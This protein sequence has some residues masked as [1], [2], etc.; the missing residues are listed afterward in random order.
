MTE[1]VLA[2][3]TNSPH[4]QPDGRS[5]LSRLVDLVRT[6]RSVS[7]ETLP[8]SGWLNLPSGVST[9]GVLWEDPASAIPP[10]TEATVLG[11]P[12]F[13]R[14]VELLASALANAPLAAQRYDPVLD[15]WL[16][17]RPGPPVLS[18][19][20]NYG[21][22]WGWHY[23]ATRDLILFG[24]HFSRLADPD[25]DGMPTRLIPI[26]ATKVELAA[27]PEGWLAWRIDGTP[28]PW[29]DVFHVSA[30]NRSGFILGRG[31][32]A[33]YRDALSGALA[34][35]SHARRYMASG[36]L[37]SA[38]L[39]SKNPDLTQEQ[40][41]AMKA[42]YRETIGTGSR[43]PLVLPASTEFTPVVSDADKQQLV[44]A[45]KWDAAEA[46]MILGI[47]TVKLGLPGPTMTYTNTQMSEIEYRTNTLSRWTGPL[48][49]A[50]TK[51]L[52]PPGD[53]AVHLWDSRLELDEATH[54]DVLSKRLAAGLI[55]IDEGRRGLGL[56]PLD[57]A[58]IEPPDTLDGDVSRETRPDVSRETR[59]DA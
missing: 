30:G 17:L 13:G 3:K 48:E 32:I 16:T 40:A 5:F 20:V 41:E 8:A 12:P 28:V 52:L 26:D 49:A 7:R 29:G 53:R 18:D 50:V 33:Q 51:W 47:P 19:P 31:V 58:G 24:N 21:T 37:P 4:P 25:D 14:G 38:V 59:A 34:T 46:A 1:I 35:Q 11:L 57:P 44:D 39:Q 36:G 6:R 43:E 42:R 45:R 2:T 9:W 56:R 55:T 23:A 27:T 10:V 22:R 15:I 54:T